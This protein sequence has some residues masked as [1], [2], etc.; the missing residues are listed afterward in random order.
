LPWLRYV[1]CSCPGCL[2]PDLVGHPVGC[3]LPFTGCGLRFGLVCLPHVPQ[4]HTP[5]YTHIYP[6]LSYIPFGPFGWLVTPL[7]APHPFGYGCLALPTHGWVP[8]WITFSSLLVLP[9]PLDSFGC[10]WIVGCLYPICPLVGSLVVGL[11]WVVPHTDYIPRLV[12]FTVPLVPWLYMPWFPH[13]WIR[14]DCYSWLV[15]WL[16]HVAFTHIPWLVPTLVTFTVGLDLFRLYIHL[17]TQLVGQLGYTVYLGPHMP[18]HTR[19]TLPFATWTGSLDCP[20]LVCLAP[21]LCHTPH[22]WFPHIALLGWLHTPHHTWFGYIGLPSRFD[23]RSHTFAHTRYVVALPGCWLHPLV[24]LDCPTVWLPGFSWC[25]FTRLLVGYLIA[26]ALHVTCHVA[27]LPVTGDCLLDYPD[28]QPFTFAFTHTSFT[29][30][31]HTPLRWDHTRCPLVGWLDLV[32]FTLLHLIWLIHTHSSQVV[33]SS[34]GFPVALW[35][36]IVGFTPGSRLRLPLVTPRLPGWT[37]CCGYVCCTLR[38][39]YVAARCHTFPLYSL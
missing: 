26:V 7:V 5:L 22:S 24:T 1:P 10:V 36:Y 29:T 31:T 27:A 3:T 4:F 20:H 30:Y 25:T 19:F 11:P 33:G 37:G 16:P 39:R 9:L 15:G 32:A 17:Y 34:Y 21:F 13:G 28:S 35:I 14:L 2:C 38:S 23:L 18:T 12:G 6:L 8:I